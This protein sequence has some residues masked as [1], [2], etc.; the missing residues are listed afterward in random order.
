MRNLGWSKYLSP[1]ESLR[2]LPTLADPNPSGRALKGTVSGETHLP[3]INTPSTNET[4]K[5]LQPTAST[6][7]TNRN[8]QPTETTTQSKPPQIRYYDGQF[9]DAR[10]NVALACTAAAAGAAVAN[11]LEAASLLKDASGAVVGARVTDRQT[12]RS[13]DVHAR[14]VVN[15]TGPYVDRLRRLSDPSVKNAVTASAG[16]HVTLPEYYGAG[17]VGMIV[18]KTKDGRVVFM[19]PW[20]G[21]VIAG[22]TDSPIEAS[23]ASGVFDRVAEGS[24]GAIEY[25]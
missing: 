19:L 4:L 25:G 14:V 6:Q 17:A 5:W 21:R 12:G 15:A 7:P 8:N 23:G 20:E 24:E 3:L 18:P 16:S 11:H 13:F 2:S 9:D 22:T 1:S 10:L